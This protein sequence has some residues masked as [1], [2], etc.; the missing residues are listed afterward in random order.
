MHTYLLKSMR[1]G[2]VDVHDNWISTLEEVSGTH[3]RSYVSLLSLCVYLSLFA[4]EQLF[5]G[6]GPFMLLRVFPDEVG[7]VGISQQRISISRGVVDQRQQRRRESAAVLDNVAADGVVSA[8]VG[9]V[10]VLVSAA[11]P[12]RLSCDRPVINHKHVKIIKKM[13]Q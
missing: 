5:Q 3:T 9:V 11:A 2:D 10:V 6:D 12:H 7:S 1:M 8:S 4:V 13:G